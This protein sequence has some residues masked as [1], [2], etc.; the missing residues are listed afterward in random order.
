ML[1]ETAEDPCGIGPFAWLNRLTVMLE[2][3]VVDPMPRFL[4][5]V[6]SNVSRAEEWRKAFPIL[7]EF[8]LSKNWE[9]QASMY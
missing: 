2:A 3:Y 6:A 1:G 8:H 4:K 5:E 9:N 7:V